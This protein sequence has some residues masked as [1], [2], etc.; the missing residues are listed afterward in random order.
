VT[1][2]AGVDGRRLLQNG[3]R[4]R[5]IKKPSWCLSKSYLRSM[6]ITTEDRGQHLLPSVSE[7]TTHLHGDCRPGKGT[8]AGIISS[9]GFI[10]WVMA[11]R[12]PALVSRH[13]SLRIRGLDT[14]ASISQNELGVPECPSHEE[15]S[16]R[17][18]PQATI[19]S[20]PS[21]SSIHRHSSCR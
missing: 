7:V 8:L 20:S 13:L 17:C 11:S 15:S 19:S 10:C 1:G 9:K 18:P 5:R 4:Y 14:S 16:G 12:L 3:S 21:F 6:L 2:D